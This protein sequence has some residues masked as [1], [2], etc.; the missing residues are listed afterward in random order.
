[1]IN[2]SQTLNQSLT[3]NACHIF[4][5][6]CQSF[7]SRFR[8]LA[9][10][11]FALAGA[12]IHSVAGASSNAGLRW[13]AYSVTAIEVPMGLASHSAVEFHGHWARSWLVETVWLSSDVVVA[14]SRNWT[15]A[16]APKSGAKA[17]PLK[18]V[19]NS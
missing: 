6:I 17:P 8:I 16:K 19:V 9:S 11:G 13:R 10:D 12:D 1:M 18:S 14:A 15:G 7:S 4:Q 3:G 2:L 5:Y